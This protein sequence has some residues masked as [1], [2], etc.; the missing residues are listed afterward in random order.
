MDTII[1]KVFEIAK[2]LKLVSKMKISRVATSWAVDACCVK[3][4]FL[5]ISLSEY[6]RHDWSISPYDTLN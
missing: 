1:S 4:F 6:V 2:L 5:I 3:R